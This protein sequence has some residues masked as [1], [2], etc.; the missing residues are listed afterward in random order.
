MK[1]LSDNVVRMETGLPN[2]QIFNIVVGYVRRFKDFLNHFAG[3]NTIASHYPVS[4]KKRGAFV[5]L[6][7]HI[8]PLDHRQLNFSMQ[9][10]V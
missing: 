7:R 4:Q 6:W 8:E 5:G 10:T 9:P 2:K 3:W 1:N